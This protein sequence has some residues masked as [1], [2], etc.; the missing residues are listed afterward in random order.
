M[1]TATHAAATQLLPTVR[2]DSHDITR[3]VIGHNPMKGRL[4]YSPQL[5]EE[6][7]R[8][9]LDVDVKVANLRRCVESGIN[10]AQGGG[11]VMHAALRA[12]ADEGGRVQWIATVYMNGDGRSI[13]GVRVTL[14]QE[15]DAVLSVTPRAIGL[16]HFGEKTDQMYVEGRT[17]QIREN[18]RRFRDTGLLVGLCTH[19]PE[20][21]DLAETERWDVDFY[22]ASFY[23]VYSAARLG[24][25]SRDQEQFSDDDR[26]RMVS[27]IGQASKPCLAFK[28]L[29]ANRKCGTPEEVREALQ[30]AYARIKPTDVKCVGMWQ[31]H[32]H[33]VVE[34]CATVRRILG[35][36]M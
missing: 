27:T 1:Q 20:V 31:K 3:L 11:E 9:H 6:M 28:V 30:L 35:P 21:I 17:A 14:E 22:Q 34:N 5:S 4:H 8:Y 25:I 13:L 32:R 24:R 10:T 29:G 18:L 2:W 36:R 23:N 16:Q 12:F 33:Q 19:L 26:D 7:K 15:L